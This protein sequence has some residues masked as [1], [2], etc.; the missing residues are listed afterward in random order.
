VTTEWGIYLALAG[1]IALVLSSLGLIAE[2]RRPASVG[3]A[4]PPEQG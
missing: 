2:V 3:G 4:I 1:S